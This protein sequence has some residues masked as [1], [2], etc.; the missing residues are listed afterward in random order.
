[1][2]NIV[3]RYE[4]LK[5]WE[6]IGNRVFVYGRRKTGKSFFIKNFTNYDYYFFIKR[7]GGIIDII[8]NKDIS[9]DY[10]KDILLSRKKVVID[11][12]QRLQEDLLDFIHANYEKI[13]LIL[14]TSTLFLS[15]KILEKHSPLLG[16]FE[17]FRI[18]LI[19]ERDIIKYLIDKENG[20]ELI[21]KAIYFREPWIIDFVKGNIREELARIFKENK[22]TFESLIGEI[23]NE[24]ERELNKT[25]INILTSIASGK[26]KSTE[27]SSYLFS[28]KIIE[29]DDPS[30][31]QS[32]L[33]ILQNIGLIN[34]INVFNK[35]FDYYIISSPLL[36][37]YFYLEGKYGISENDI[38]YEII[39]EVVNDK[40]PFHVEYFF[41]SLL[42]KIY[43]LNYYKIVEKNYE[44]DISLFKFKELK[45]V[46]EVKWKDYIDKNEIKEIENK[47]NKFNCR[48]ILI[49]PNKNNL[50]Y[51]P[52]NIEVLDVNDIINLVK[53]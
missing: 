37:I 8:N 52:E 40:I 23:F 44:I 41:N 25:Y 48:K 20:K 45:I 9:Y 26:N 17:E 16:L 22:Y 1:M 36:D 4:D 24:E 49:L 28:K 6:K 2:M 51:Y 35:K 33:K 31:I 30:I 43:G 29:K 18:D 39:K 15:K 32:Y 46:G 13:N 47:L 11:E 42:S 38:V 7:D 21:E 12:F 19:D 14:I 27:I 50:E 5:R 53:I 3:I 10:L 34:K